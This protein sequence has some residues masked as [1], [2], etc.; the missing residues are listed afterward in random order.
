MFDDG[1]DDDNPIKSCIL[2]FNKRVSF[3]DSLSMYAHDAGHHN[4]F[5]Q[6][7]LVLKRGQ[8]CIEKP[9]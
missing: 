5:V 7:F 8:R 2:Y 9:S 6:E 1:S 3:K 4:V